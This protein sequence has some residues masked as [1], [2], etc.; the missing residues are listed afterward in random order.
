MASTFTSYL[1]DPS[2]EHLHCSSVSGRNVIHLFLSPNHGP[3][4]ASGGR[5]SIIERRHNVPS[6]FSLDISEKR[7]RTYGRAGRIAIAL[8]GTFTSKCRDFAQPQA[9]WNSYVQTSLRE[10]TEFL[11][12]TCNDRNFDPNAPCT[13]EDSCVHA[14]GMQWY[15]YKLMRMLI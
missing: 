7:G 8:S 11:N 6:I 14:F 5:H 12:E 9:H 3:R 13:E 15:L 1:V 10:A 4:S 2:S